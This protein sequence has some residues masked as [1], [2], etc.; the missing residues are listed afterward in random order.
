MSHRAPIFHLSI[1]YISS[2]Y[3]DWE[4]SHYED[5][6]LFEILDYA[7]LEFIHTKFLYWMLNPSYHKK[8][9]KDNYAREFLSRNGV[10]CSSN[11]KIKVLYE[12][13]SISELDEEESRRRSDLWIV[14]KDGDVERNIIVENKLFSEL[15][16]AQ[17]CQEINQYLKNPGDVYI[18]LLF[19]FHKQEY[20]S[21]INKSDLIKKYIKNGTF[22]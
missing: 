3:Q 18:A 8:T 4:K 20:Y 22:N 17:A 11:A 19:D 15:T 7:N 16:E 10:D 2:K 9:Y 1:D 12:K 21:L 6:N 14:V 5:L 13:P